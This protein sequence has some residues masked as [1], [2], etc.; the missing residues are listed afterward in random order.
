MTIISLSKNSI[1]R[2]LPSLQSLSPLGLSNLFSAAGRDN[3]WASSECWAFRNC[4]TGGYLGAH[5]DG[6]VICEDLD[7]MHHD[8]PFRVLPAGGYR[9][10]LQSYINYVFVIVDTRQMI[11]AIKNKAAATPWEVEGLS[12]GRVAFF[13]RAD[14]KFLGVDGE[15]VAISTTRTEAFEW[16]LT[17]VDAPPPRK[18][19]EVR[20]AIYNTSFPD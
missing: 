4:F 18:K 16:E 19:K 11:R 5:A 17:A 15:A 1:N 10:Y 20:C 14:N 7:L 12:N 3:D 8:I 6:E 13:S 9:V 2:S